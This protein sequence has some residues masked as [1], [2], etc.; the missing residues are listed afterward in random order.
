M[1]LTLQ[2]CKPVQPTPSP[3]MHQLWYLLCLSR[4]DAQPRPLEVLLLGLASRL[5]VHLLTVL[6]QI[7]S[8]PVPVC[9]LHLDVILF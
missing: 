8:S 5:K 1:A 7:H 6:S 4:S 9:L 3:A 2:V